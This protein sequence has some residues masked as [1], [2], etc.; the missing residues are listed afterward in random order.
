VLTIVFAVLPFT[1]FP[2]LAVKLPLAFS[3]I[4][5]IRSCVR[6]VADDLKRRT[7]G[8]FVEL[9]GD[10]QTDNAKLKANLLPV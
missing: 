3:V 4:N 10:L 2:T 5:S 1:R 7:K 6:V 8:S 9:Q